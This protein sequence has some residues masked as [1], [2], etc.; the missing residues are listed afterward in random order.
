MGRISGKAVYGLEYFGKQHDRTSLSQV[1]PLSSISGSFDAFFWISNLVGEAL[2]S[3]F[4]FLISEQNSAQASTLGE[5]FPRFRPM[6]PPTNDARR[7]EAKEAYPRLGS[8]AARQTFFQAVDRLPRPRVKWLASLQ[9][10]KAK[11]PYFFFPP[12]DQIFSL[13]PKY[14]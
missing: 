5:Y 7:Y 8:L 1:D 3:D 6:D 10:F 14:K 2:K 11:P 4:L 9:W 13:F 12:N